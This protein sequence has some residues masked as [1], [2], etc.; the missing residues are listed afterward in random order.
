MPNTA[1]PTRPVA[2]GFYYMTHKYDSKKLYPAVAKY[3]DPDR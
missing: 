3:F 2:F 1:T